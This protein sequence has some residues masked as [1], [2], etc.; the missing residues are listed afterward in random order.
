M[1]DRFYPTNA[2]QLLFGP[3]TEYLAALGTEQ[4]GRAERVDIRAEQ[5]RRYEER[6][7][8]ERQRLAQQQAQ[9]V[10]GVQTALSGMPAERALEMAPAAAQAFKTMGPTGEAAAKGYAPSMGAPNER[11]LAL[12]EGL[13]GMPSGGEGPLPFPPEMAGMA[14]Q[15]QGVRVE[16]ST[17]FPGTAA[18]VSRAG[19]E[20]EQA[21][22][23]VYEKQRGDLGK[24]LSKFA[25]RTALDVTLEG[26]RRTPVTPEH[27]EELLARAK[28]EQGEARAHEVE[29]AKAKKSARAAP[30]GPQPRMIPD[31]RIKRYFREGNVAAVAR[32]IQSGNI[33][34]MAEATPEDIDAYAQGGLDGVRA[35]RAAAAERYAGDKQ[36]AGLTKLIDKEYA[37]L[38]DVSV[39]WD[40]EKVAKAQKAI[41]AMELK[42]DAAVERAASALRTGGTPSGLDPEQTTE[43]KRQLSLPEDQAQKEIREAADLGATLPDGTPFGDVVSMSRE[44]RH[45]LYRRLLGETK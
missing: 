3:L 1:G 39:K 18:L 26:H 19:R 5:K 24:G 20:R 37:K 36:V 34:E 2:G 41:T 17:Q 4:R 45:R 16:P 32:A 40:P 33:P 22:G 15:A 42:R 13:A 28:A 44:A 11:L 25:P 6:M 23:D 29:V 30:R 10:L 21:S 27:L 31:S 9:D 38:K 12:S 43:L 7:A 8:L 14:P 35:E